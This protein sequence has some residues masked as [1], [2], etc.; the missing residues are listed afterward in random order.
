MVQGSIPLSLI[1][2][3]YLLFYTSSVASTRDVFRSATT[4]GISNGNLCSLPAACT[5]LPVSVLRPAVPDKSGKG[6]ERARI[7][8]G[9]KSLLSV[10][11]ILFCIHW[12]KRLWYVGLV[13][14][15]TNLSLRTESL[16]YQKK[17]AFTMQ[18]TKPWFRLSVWSWPRQPVVELQTHFLTIK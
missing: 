18:K 11:N 14:R 7:S 15:F 13:S 17:K 1:F 10:W 3:K 4:T 16:D 12:Q 5:S 2:K 8:V 6:M 9:L